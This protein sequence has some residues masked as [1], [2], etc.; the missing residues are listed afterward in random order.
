MTA[1]NQWATRPADQRFETLAALRDSVNARRMRS[2]AQDAVVKRCVI[3]AEGDEIFVNGETTKAKPSHWAFG[4]LSTTLGAPAGYLRGIPAPLAAQCLMHGVGQMDEGA[5]K[6][7]SLAPENDGDARILQAVTS[8]SYGRI[9]DADVADCAGRIVEKTGGRF[10][11][12][13]AYVSGGGTNRLGGEVKPSGLYASDRD[14]FIFMIDGG[15]RL[16]VGPRAQLNRGFFMWNSEVGARTFGLT[17]FLFNEVCGNHIVWGAQDV[18]TFV[19]RHSKGG[20]YRFDSEALPRLLAYADASAK[21]LEGAIRAAMDFDIRKDY[22]GGKLTF[23]N[24]K[25]FIGNKVKGAKFTQV[26]IREAIAAAEREEGQCE[27]L[28]DLSQGLTAYARGF[29]FLDARTD[30]ETR[31]GKLLDLVKP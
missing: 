30:L 21:P 8:P 6:F 24:V 26:E 1:S 14:I 25:D 19:V 10:F 29:E 7:M 4:Q 23:E 16:D 3:T 17:T 18:N 11:N 22:G 27:T 5:L 13:K 31:A 2:R 20:P 28:W 9:W 15:S 12:P